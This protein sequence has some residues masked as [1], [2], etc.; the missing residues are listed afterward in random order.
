MV[1]RAIDI[2]LSCVALLLL[3]PVFVVITLLVMLT[4]AGG[5][6][7]RQARVGRFG[8]TFQLLKFRT[9]RIGSEALGQITV[10]ARDPRITQVGYLLRRTKLDELPQLINVLVGDMSIVGPRPEVP[11]YVG[12]YTEEQRQV[13]MVRP[14]LTS[15]ASLAYINENEI[16]GRSP[17]PEKTYTEVVM[18][19]KLAM[20][21]AYV[22]E[23]SLWLDIRIILGTARKL[24]VG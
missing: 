13:L 1:K 24:L 21:L 23:Q 4:S 18:P 16:L 20:D 7:F 2:L 11:Q 22:Q 8:R 5:P 6:F 10:G 12:L 3:L 14:G 17:H 19:A 15:A 9:M